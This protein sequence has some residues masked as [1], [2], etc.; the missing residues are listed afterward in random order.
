MNCTSICEISCNEHI[1]STTS[2]VIRTSVRKE[3]CM[4][5]ECIFDPNTHILLYMSTY[6]LYVYIHASLCDSSL[7]LC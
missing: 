7:H 5:V 4:Y 2:A 3:R 1:Q 6:V